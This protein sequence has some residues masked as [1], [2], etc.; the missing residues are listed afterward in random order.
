MRWAAGILLCAFSLYGQTGAPPVPTA[1]AAPAPAVST[2]TL[3][4]FF[5]RHLGNLDTQANS[6]D[7]QGQNGSDLRNYYQTILVLSD[8]DAATLKQNAA[9]CV[10]AVQ[11]LDQQAQVI[12]Q[13]MR[14]PF[15]GGKIQAGQ[16][17]PAPD[18]RL[19]QLTA[20]RDAVTNSQIQTLQSGLTSG[21]FQKIDTYVRTQ[22]AA[23]VSSVP[24]VPHPPTGGPLGSTPAPGGNQ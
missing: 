8:Q 9:A 7:A 23:Q 19:K 21:S 24:I 11:Q 15:P 22:F 10:T 18:P 4:R 2:P 20:Q 17:L 5:F 1:P 13:Q 14:A 16:S 3:Y 6:M 12:I